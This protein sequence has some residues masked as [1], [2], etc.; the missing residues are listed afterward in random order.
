MGAV[1]ILP[2]SMT[3]ASGHHGRCISR[4]V[5]RRSY[6]LCIYIILEI[7]QPEGSADKLELDGCV[8]GGGWIFVILLTF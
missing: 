2:A 1:E 8:S 6:T 3:A 5:G 4:F 7:L